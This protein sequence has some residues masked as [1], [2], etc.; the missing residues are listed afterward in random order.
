[1]I[2][3]AGGLR[4]GSGSR[5][6]AARRV[7]M[8]HR[9]HSV[10][11]DCVYVTAP[12]KIAAQLTQVK[13]NWTDTTE[14]VKDPAYEEMV[15]DERYMS[16]DLWIKGRVVNGGPTDDPTRLAL[17]VL[18]GDTAAA[19][20]LADHVQ[21][22]HGGNEGAVAEVVR[23]KVEMA[24]EE[25]REACAKVADEVVATVDV[26]NEITLAWETTLMIG[27]RIRTRGVKEST[28]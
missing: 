22:Q 15:L 24:K 1:M 13:A 14:E 3:D 17:A 5:R 28:P 27:A 4:K 19:L 12:G 10:N 16:S 8:P 18:S 20:L 11:L 23:L 9:K 21:M 2:A 7:T 25:E 26:P 6:I